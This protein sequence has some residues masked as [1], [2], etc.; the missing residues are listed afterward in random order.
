MHIY[1]GLQVSRHKHMKTA[2][3][4]AHGTKKP[5]GTNIKTPRQKETHGTYKDFR[6]TCRELTSGGKKNTCYSNTV[7][8]CVKN[9]RAAMENHI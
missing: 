2:T 9:G 4:I 5:H 6:V 1:G 8:K 3:Q 7:R